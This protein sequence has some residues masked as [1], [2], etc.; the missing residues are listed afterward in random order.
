MRWTAPTN[1]G[2]S[3]IT[4]YT[5]RVYAGTS[6]TVLKTVTAAGSATSLAVT[7]LTNGTSY[8]FT[9]AATNAAGT[10]PASARSAAVTPATVPTAPAIGVPT[11]GNASAT[12]RWTAPTN[13]GGSAITGYTVR[14][15]TGTST[16]VLK[17][18]TAAGSATSLAVTGLTNGTSY[19][20][21]VAAD[22]RRRHRGLL[23]PVGGR[24]TGD[25]THGTGHPNCNRR[26]HR[27]SHHRH[28]HV[29]CAHL[30]RRRTDHRLPSHRFAHVGRWCGPRP[31]NLGC[32]A[33]NQPVPADDRARRR[34]LPV[35]RPGH[36]RGRRESPIG[37]LQPRGRP[38]SPTDLG[39]GSHRPRLP[40][41]NRSVL[42]GTRKR[43][44]HPPA[45]PF[46]LPL[47]GQA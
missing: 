18:V 37:P 32:P 13:T 5:V 31:N 10:G 46:R 17:T 38:I 44:D 43:C 20:F 45:D 4:G 47:S 36:Q 39:P 26:R 42:V 28:R 9:V 34:Q 16:T 24:H 22:Q 11:R 15:Y 6:T 23:G 1:T 35:H 30:H 40:G 3:A 21:T 2:G 7:G 19:T 29:G 27:R 8:T 25:R 33:G 41:P 12:V 14:V